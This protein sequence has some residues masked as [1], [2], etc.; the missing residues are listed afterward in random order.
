MEN[1]ILG[2][3]KSKRFWNKFFTKFYIAFQIVT[4]DSTYIGVEIVVDNLRG[5]YNDSQKTI[6]YDS[7]GDIT[8]VPRGNFVPMEF[9]LYQNY[10]NPFNPTTKIRFIVPESGNYKLEVFNTL[11]QKVET[12]LD[13]Y[14]AP[15]IQE[16]S[17]NGANLPSESMC[18]DSNLVL[19]LR[20][21]NDST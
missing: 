7:F 18:I 4:I 12:L 5:F 2:Y 10:P 19:F 13:A 16:Y 9:V 15:G 21:K 1:V 17:F 6:V 11:G 8:S 3:E 20:Q 14:L